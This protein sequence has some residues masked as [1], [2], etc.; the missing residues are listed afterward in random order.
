MLQCCFAENQALR[1]HLQNEK[2]FGASVTKQES[3]VLLMESLL[4]GSL[5]WFLCIVC[6]A[7]PLPILFQ[8][9]RDAVPM[10][11]A[12]DKGQKSVAPRGPG[13]KIFELWLL[14]SYIKS[15][16]CKASKTKMKPSQA[17]GVLV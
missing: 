11:N 9:S 6:L 2:A 14:Q 16:R 7:L 8:L 5:L 13:S 12:E 1:L 3:A 17:Y 4:L 15:K 10:G